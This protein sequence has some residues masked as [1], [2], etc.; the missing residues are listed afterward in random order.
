VITAARRRRG[1]LPALIVCGGLTIAIVAPL[2][3]SGTLLLLDYGTYPAGPNAQLDA[4]VW[5][6]PPGL[7]TRAPVDVVLYAVFRA[8][9]WGWLRLLPFVIF[10]PLVWLGFRR[11]LGTRTL[12]VAAATTLFVVNPWTDDRMSAGQVYLIVGYA[13][14]PLLTSMLF[15]RRARPLTHAVL[16]GLLFALLIAL[17]PHFI[18]IAGLLVAVALGVHLV[19]RDWQRAKEIGGAMIAVGA[20][21]VYWLVPALLFHPE[22]LPVTNADLSAFA[23]SSDAR[24]GLGLNVLGL[25]GF[26]RPGNPLAKASL[27]GWPF[28]LLAI[29]VLV[30]VGAWFAWTRMRSRSLVVV[31]GVTAVIAYFL[32]LGNQGPTGGLFILLYDHVPGFAIM[33]EPEKFSALL[34]LAYATFFGIGVTCLAGLARRVMQRRFVTALAMAIPC[35]YGFTVFWG[36]SG[37]ATPSV[38]PASWA[39][40]NSILGTGDQAVLALPWHLYLDFPWT[41][42]RTVVN[43]MASYFQRPVISGDNIEAGDIETES[44]DPRSDYLNY[45]FSVGSDTTHLGRLLAPLG[46]RYVLLAKTDDWKDYSFLDTQSDIRVVRNWGDLTLFENME[47]SP[48]ATA[49][50]ATITVDTWG[51]V[52]GLAQETSL[53]DYYVVVRNPGPGPIREPALVT[54]ASSGAAPAV[55]LTS[56]VQV[57]L[58]TTGA[59][60]HIV[61]AEPYD[62]DW[63]VNGQHASE[64]LG[65]L[66]GFADVPAGTLTVTYIRWSAVRDSYIVSGGILLTL[67]ALIAVP[68]Y[69]RRRLRRTARQSLEVFNTPVEPLAE[70]A[71][72]HGRR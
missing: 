23:T 52:V 37:Y 7:V 64:E 42:G 1:M 38:Y 35:V 15:I 62:S 47:P 51:D 32:A 28:L 39:Q 9:D 70:P 49:P 58:H 3:H 71:A 13:L 29:L 33:R 43:P 18:F 14:L 10:A 22:A 54:P 65:A 16:T 5:G 67:L 11:L 19:F 20:I 68:A 61:V 27:S 41:Q 48:L 66:T 72:P 46:I 31:L 2:L 40:A 21:S 45:L 44:S 24:Y 69:R 6:F 55:Q 8:L 56:P 36:F 12:A 30:G 57:T 60:A 26:W 50:A 63:T 53:A 17:A 25:Y 59:S 4:S 34:A